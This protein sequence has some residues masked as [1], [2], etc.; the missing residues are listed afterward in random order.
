MLCWGGSGENAPPFGLADVPS[1]R[2]SALST[3]IRYVSV[4]AIREQLCGTDESGR[5]YCTEEPTPPGRYVDLA[6]GY[7]HSCAAR[8]DGKVECWALEPL[9]AQDFGQLDVP[10]ELR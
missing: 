8:T 9:G 1:G 3:D 6:L 4:T 5:V 10:D 7:G 2:Y